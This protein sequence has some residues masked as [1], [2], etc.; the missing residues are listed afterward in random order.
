MV[1]WR[2]LAVAT[3][4]VLAG[5]AGLAADPAPTETITPAPVPEDTPTPSTPPPPSLAP[6]VTAGGVED[7]DRLAAAHRAA[8]GNRSYTL[9]VTASI[10]GDA[11]ANWTGYEPRQEGG[12]VLLLS[13]RRV[14]RVDAGGF[15][16]SEVGG[17]DGRLSSGLPEA[18]GIGAARVGPP[19]TAAVWSDG[20]TSYLRTVGDGRVT[21]AIGTARAAASTSLDPTAM[22]LLRPRFE[23][24]PTSAAPMS[25]AGRR[26]IV[27]G[28]ATDVATPA[29]VTAGAPVAEP[30]DVALTAR[31]SDA[32]LVLEFDLRYRATLDGRPVAVRVSLEIRDLDATTVG[33]P[34]WIDEAENATG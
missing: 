16:R 27:S 32:G 8:L 9:V 1:P 29:L 12:R 22:D 11:G 7:V 2:T 5:C 17:V 15:P 21:Y 6:G 31:V 3:A 28:F 26:V 10:V 34:A 4:V 30:R 19:A 23:A 20:T 24:V 14:V 13:T 18:F 25:T 33:R